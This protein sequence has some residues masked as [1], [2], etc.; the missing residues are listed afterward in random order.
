M[1]RWLALISVGAFLGLT[2][3]AAAQVCS[4]LASFASGALQVSGTAQFN[5]QAKTFGGGFAFGGRGAFGQVGVGTTSY[6]AFDG[7]TFFFAG[8]AGYQV[9]LDQKG[10]FHLCPMASIVHGSGPN[11]I[12]YFGDGSL[13]LDFSQTDLSF[14]LGF[15]VLPAQVGST[16]VIPTVSF[17]VVNATVTGKDDVSGQSDSQSETFELLGL[18]LGIVFNQV[19]T[20]RPGVSIPMGLD[21]ASTTFGAIV[22]VNFGRSAR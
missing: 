9:A 13:I 16:R 5:D 7:S 12:D 20:V 11:N 10:V 18:G 1:P 3:P 8:S 2:A 4:G 15:G 21:G 17:S 19:I 14:G 6:D 22:S